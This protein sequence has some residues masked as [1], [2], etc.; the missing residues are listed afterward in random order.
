M[1]DITRKQRS[2]QWGNYEFSGRVTGPDEILIENTLDGR[3]IDGNCPFDVPRFDKSVVRDKDK[4]RD[5]QRNDL[6]R[7]RNKPW[8]N[9]WAKE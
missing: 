9:Q 5:F 1:H 4:V 7:Y 6:K 8:V 3:P 2:G